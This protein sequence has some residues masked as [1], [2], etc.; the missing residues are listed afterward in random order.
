MTSVSLVIPLYNQLAYTR[1]CLD[2]LTRSTSEPYELIL[3][4]NASSDGT[5][6]W[7]DTVKAT[8]IRNAENLGC[9]KAWNQG[10]RASTGQVVAILNNDLVL[11]RGWLTPLL[12]F[13]RATGH[14]IVSPAAREGPLNYDL[15]AYAA[16]YTA[17]C[18]TATR[19]RIYGSCM[20]IRRDVF[21]TVGLFDEAFTYGGYEDMDFLW[22]VQAAGITVGMTGASLIHH[23][24]LVTRKAVVAEMPTFENAN[25][26][27][28]TRKWNRTVGGNWL[29]RRWTYVADKLRGR[30]ERFR[31]GHMLVEK[32][33]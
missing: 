24:A 32:Y 5:G 31:Y 17:R 1:Q 15:D 22:R 4:D 33:S 8:V 18:R 16:A 27:H 14:G 29:N 23:F 9:A 3:I 21:E 2:S 26:A 28:F 11:S 19:P 25:L 10:I 13:M 20:L 6:A 7:L 12:D 30:Y